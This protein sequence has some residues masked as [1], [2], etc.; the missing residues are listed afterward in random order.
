[1]H[2]QYLYFFGIKTSMSFSEI[3]QRLADVLGQE[4]MQNDEALALSVPA[5]TSQDCCAY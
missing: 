1:M 3:I 4:L 2:I 5:F